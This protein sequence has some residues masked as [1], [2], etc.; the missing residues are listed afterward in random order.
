MH[1]FLM[2]N[3][4]SELIFTILTFEC[5]A[6]IHR[7]LMSSK[8]TF[9]VCLKTTYWK[10]CLLILCKDFKQLLV[11][12]QNKQEPSLPKKNKKTVQEDL[13]K[14]IKLNFIYFYIVHTSNSSNTT[15]CK[16]TT[17]TAQILPMLGSSFQWVQC[18]FSFTVCFAVA[19]SCLI[20]SKSF[21]HELYHLT[22]PLHIK[23]KP[24]NDVWILG[25]V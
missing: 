23:F 22:I 11:T 6:H 21:A 1:K 14:N 18:Y 19:F 12:L 9:P 7:F 25:S 24:N 17:T 4:E 3:K 8:V 20:F 2:S 13:L 16:V 5:L 10:V 15:R